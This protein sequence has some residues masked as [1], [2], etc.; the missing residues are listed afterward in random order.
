M[1]Y[2]LFLG[3]PELSNGSVERVEEGEPFSHNA[4]VSPGFPEEITIFEWYFNGVELLSTGSNPD[5]SVYP[6]I[7]FT[8]VFRNH[9]GNYTITATNDGGTASGFFILDVQC[10]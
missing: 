2:D 4:Q 7:N 10:W 9:S 5:I 1:L 3:P 6:S 8:Q